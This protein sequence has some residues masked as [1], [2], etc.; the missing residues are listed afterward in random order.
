MGLWDSLREAASAAA[1]DPGL[2]ELPGDG[3]TF[4][5]CEEGQA[6]GLT[7]WTLMDLK[8]RSLKVQAGLV[9]FS[10]SPWEVCANTLFQLLVAW[11]S[12]HL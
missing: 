1:R 9:P 8:S 6:G 2:W 5:S 11:V 7:W 4:F 10:A 12:L 3:V